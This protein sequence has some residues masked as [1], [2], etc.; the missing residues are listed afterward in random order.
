MD[1]V[2]LAY[3]R[4]PVRLRR[5]LTE[6]PIDRR[7]LAADPLYARLLRAALMDDLM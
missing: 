3:E 4:R 5:M 6:P 2:E 1:W 7:G